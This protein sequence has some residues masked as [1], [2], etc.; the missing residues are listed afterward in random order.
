MKEKKF[1]NVFIITFFLS[2]CSFIQ[3][4]ATDDQNM[5]NE[6]SSHSLLTRFVHYCDKTHD[7]FKQSYPGQSIDYTQ[8]LWHQAHKNPLIEIGA[9]G[10]TVA[11]TQLM[12]PTFLSTIVLGFGAAEILDGI[13]RIVKPIIITPWQSLVQ[14][15][16]KKFGQESIKTIMKENTLS[17]QKTKKEM[18]SRNLIK[19]G[20]PLLNIAASSFIGIQELSTSYAVY[21]QGINPFSLSLPHEYCADGTYLCTPLWNSGLGI[22]CLANGLYNMREIYECY[23]GTIHKK[24]M[25]LFRIFNTIVWAMVLKNEEILGSL[26]DYYMSMPF[27][28]ADMYNRATLV[29]E[30]LT[31][32][33]E[34]ENA[35]YYLSIQI[36]DEY[37]Q[38]LKWPTNIIEGIAHWTVVEGI[39]GIFQRGGQYIND[40]IRSREVQEVLDASLIKARL[41]LKAPSSHAKQ[42]K[43]PFSFN[44]NITLTEPLADTST[45]TKPNQNPIKKVKVK[46]RGKLSPSTSIQEQPVQ[47][48][49]AI[50]LNAD[51]SRKLTELCTLF[52]TQTSISMSELNTHITEICALKHLKYEPHGNKNKVAL[53]TYAFEPPHGNENLEGYRKSRALKALLMA[54]MHNESLQNVMDYIT[55]QNTQTYSLQGFIEVALF[56]RKYTVQTCL[57]ILFF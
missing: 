54:L 11:A 46:T 6:S 35:L 43:E 32:I 51:I 34:K 29:I 12:E 28:T 21:N 50:P 52:R 20:K 48:Q 40:H 18:L 24:D 17:V 30:N 56:E 26:I 16:D 47:Q 53:G 45:S 5:E 7:Q 2:L 14:K 4:N 27:V 38:R 25:P 10:L 49:Q 23:K 39:G 55:Q 57:F 36:I 15:F 8:K 13:E 41:N 31:S 44:K 3:V 9:G 22:I 42:T 33:Q 1:M 37:I 19:Y